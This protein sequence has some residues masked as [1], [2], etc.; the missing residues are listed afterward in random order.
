[1][2]DAP[3]LEVGDRLLDAIANLVDLFVELDLPIEKLAAL[4][5]LD[6]S[7]HA[8]ADVSFVAYRIGGIDHFEEA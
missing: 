6:G 7:V 5:F 2:Q 3:G 1:V 8:L 4:R